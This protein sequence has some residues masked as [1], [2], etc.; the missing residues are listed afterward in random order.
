MG[1]HK[2][3]IDDDM[4]DTKWLVCSCGQWIRVDTVGIQSE[5]SSESYSSR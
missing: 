1:L 2:N 4:I 5:R 3:N